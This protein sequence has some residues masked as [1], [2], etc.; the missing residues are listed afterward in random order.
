MYFQNVFSRFVATAIYSELS[1]WTGIPNIVI[2]MKNWN[3]LIIYLSYIKF[4]TLK[5]D[6]ILKEI[7]NQGINNRSIKSF[8]LLMMLFLYK[9]TFNNHYHAITRLK[10][11]IE[12]R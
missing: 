1:K 3:F 8:G 10:I 7:V 5:L 9:I 12:R 2:I 6:L 11:I 4:D